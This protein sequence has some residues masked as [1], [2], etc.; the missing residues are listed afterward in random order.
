MERAAGPV[1]RKIRAGDRELQ[2]AY[3]PGHGGI[4]GI[5][6]QRHSQIQ[7]RRPPRSRQRLRRLNTA[8]PRL[9]QRLPLQGHHPQPF[10]GLRG[11]LP[12]LRQGPEAAPRAERDI[13][14][15]RGD[16]VSRAEVRG[17]GGRFRQIYQERTQGPRRLPQQRRVLSFPYR[18]A[19]GPRGLQQGDKAGPLR[20]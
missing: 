19:Q 3:P 14:L 12:R 10:R 6:F 16:I 20:P 15:Q 11:G 2:R 18:H 1:G 17:R 8:Q 9:H 4:L 13:F 7:S 5:L